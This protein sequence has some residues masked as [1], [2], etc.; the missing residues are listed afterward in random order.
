[1]ANGAADNTL[2][3]PP[4]QHTLKV[5]FRN[6]DASQRD[7]VKRYVTNHYHAVPMRIRFVFLDDHAPGPSNIRIMFNTEKSE[8]YI[9]RDAERHPR[10]TTMWLNWHPTIQDPETRRRQ[11]QADV[12]HEFGHALGM[13]HEQKHPDCTAK[14]NYRVLQARHGWSAEKL[15]RAYEKV[16]SRRTRFS[17]YDPK[18]IMHYPIR[19][20]DALNAV[21]TVPL[22]RVLSEG[23]KQFLAAIYP[24]Q[25]T[26]RLPVKSERGKVVAPKR[27]PEVKKPKV[28]E[29]KKAVVKKAV[30]KKDVVKKPVV[31]KSETHSK[32]MVRRNPGNSRS[33]VNWNGGNIAIINNSIVNIN[34]NTVMG[35]NGKAIAMA[36]GRGAMAMV[37]G[38]GAGY[39]SA[40]AMA[41]GGNAMAMVSGGGPGQFGAWA[42]SGNGSAFASSWIRY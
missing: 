18:S 14:W 37:S 40:M 23:D 21:A 5:R 34:G 19:P 12:L 9:G 11:R 25:Q 4:E 7:A 16:D 8:S 41:G 15:Q 33:V 35:G 2:L 17:T 3:W 1:L 20:G 24:V 42:A 6:G 28:R 26:L 38:G 10:D 22:N 36:G 29:V 27:K 13:V 32:A 39:S 30:V 31:K